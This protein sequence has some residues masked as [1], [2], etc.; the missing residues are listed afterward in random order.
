M[1]F[2]S[3]NKKHSPAVHLNPHIQGLKSSA[4]VAINDLSNELK[5]QG[6]EIFKFDL[7]QSPFP[8]PESVVESLRQN[9]QQKDYLPVKGLR[10]LQGSPFFRAA[11][12]AAARMN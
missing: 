4:T 3:E 6:K 8:V 7:G 10:E 5:R 1:A 9:A 11:T 12:L 2:T